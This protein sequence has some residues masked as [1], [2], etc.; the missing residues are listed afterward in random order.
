LQYLIK[1]YLT[2]KIT[3]DM[4]EEAKEFYFL[5]GEPFNYSGWMRIATVLRGNLP[6]RIRAVPEGTV[7]PN[8]NALVTIESTDPESFWVVS[9]L[10]TVLVRL[11]YPI[12]VCTNSY[13]LKKVIDHYFD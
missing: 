7:V 5:H 3:V 13:Q 12:T 2:Q 10:E 1:K 9:W 4:V 6:V 11:W 8:S